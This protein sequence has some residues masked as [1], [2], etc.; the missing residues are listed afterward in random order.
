MTL[1]SLPY[2]GGKSMAG[3]GVGRWVNSLLPPPDSKYKGYV[4][5]FCGMAGVL[6]HRGPASREW[7][8]DKDRLIYNWWRCV[9]D[10]RDELIEMLSFTPYS[11]E[12][13]LRA[14]EQ[15]HT[16][17]DPIMQAVNVT[18]VLHQGRGRTL[19]KHSPVWARS[20]AEVSSRSSIIADRIMPLWQRIKNC[21]LYNEDALQ[22]IER[23]VAY[24]YFVVYCDPPYRT[25]VNSKRYQDN[26]SAD[27]EFIWSLSDVL[28]RHKGF[29]AI[30]GYKDEWDH[31]K[32]YRR[33]LVSK[34][35]MPE[36]EY[37]ERIDV[38][39]LNRE[40]P[41]ETLDLFEDGDFE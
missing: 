1:L 33:E 28:Q 7:L 39:W 30:T 6:C 32:W 14:H 8:N 21:H 20:G 27:K 36:N 19:G 11:Q 4:E 23:T 38:V 5:P 35:T 18:V 37:P 13:Y 22:F 2:M 26:E 31:L 24:D 15:L 9:R 17:Q 12:E 10:D 29:V 25:S 3:T 40:P 41:N 16:E 34:S